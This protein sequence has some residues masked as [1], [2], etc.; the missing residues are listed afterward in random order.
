LYRA[1]DPGKK[2]EEYAGNAGSDLEK[3]RDMALENK[4]WWAYMDASM[5]LAWMYYYAGATKELGDVLRNLEQAFQ[6]HFAD[7]LI[8]SGKVPVEKDTLIFGQFARLYV[9]RGMQAMDRFEQSDVQP[10][11]SHLR[12]A[13]REFTLALEYNGLVGASHQG[14]QRSM[15]NIRSRLKVLADAYDQQK[16]FYDAIDKVAN[17]ELGRPGEE[18]HLWRELWDDDELKDVF[19][20]Y[21]VLI[22]LVQ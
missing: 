12:E 21:Q 9:L 6:Q 13:A 5:G 22:R 20:P 17:E 7:Y 18:C 10:P 8:T 2:R 4:L 11:Y 19:E 1:S 14:Y 15:H 3:A 16:A